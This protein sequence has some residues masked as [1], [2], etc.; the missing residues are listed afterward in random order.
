MRTYGRKADTQLEAVFFF[1][2]R[3]S[4]AFKF[5]FNGFGN[6]CISDYMRTSPIT[7]DLDENS[8][9]IYAK[10]YSHFIIAYFV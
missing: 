10:C 6:E 1:H 3:L 5:A 9:Y 2:Q 7:E 8:N 4:L